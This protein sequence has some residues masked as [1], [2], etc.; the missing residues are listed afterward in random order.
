M[1]LERKGFS[2]R[3]E[4]AIMEAFRDEKAKGDYRKA[5]TQ[6]YRIA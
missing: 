2:I 1:Y 4:A 3:T 6:T 5:L